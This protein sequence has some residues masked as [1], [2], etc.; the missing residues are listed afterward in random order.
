MEEG[1]TSTMSSTAGGG[2]G[3]TAADFV[4][5]LSGLL[6]ETRVVRLLVSRRTG[7][8]DASGTGDVRREVAML[9]VEVV[10]LRADAPCALKNNTTVR[11]TVRVDNHTL[12]SEACV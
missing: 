2:R 12:K 8:F 5:A 10:E 1:A 11:A 3:L 6:T 7:T 4:G 9:G